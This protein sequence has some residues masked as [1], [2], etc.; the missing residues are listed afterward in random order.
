MR[1]D[2]IKS[3]NR[4]YKLEGIVEKLG[5]FT[6]RFRSRIEEMALYDIDTSARISALEL[7]HTLYLHNRR[8]LSSSGRDELLELIVVDN[9]RIRKAAG[10][11]AKTILEKENIQPA[12]EQAQATVANINKTWVALKCIATFLLEQTSANGQTSED[13]ENTNPL[14]ATLEEN[15]LDQDTDVM[16]TNAVDSL[17][18]QVESLQDYESIAEYLSLDH[19][20]T[21]RSEDSMEDSGLANCYR[22]TEAE[23]S[24]IVKLLTASI[25]LIITKGFDRENIKAKDRKK[26]NV[27]IYYKWCKFTGPVNE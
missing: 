8:L 17:W 25:N 9:D 2:A 23:E 5:T 18:S 14:I 21:Q 26:L 4:L 12:I 22:L 10:P 19:S 27:R 6:M 24:I 16:V 13:S 11:L 7:C 3:V 20:V 1:S 15:N